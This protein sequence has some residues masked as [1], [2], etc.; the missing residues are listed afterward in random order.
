[1]QTFLPYADFK[2]CADVLDNKRLNKQHVECFQII[3]TL[4]TN[5]KS[6]RQHPITRMWENNIDALKE[7]ANCIKIECLNRNFKSEK[8]PFYTLPNEII[9]PKWL[10]W[11]LVHISHQSNLMRK[12]ASYYSQFGWKE[13]DITG[14]YWAVTPKTKQ[15]QK[16]NE[17][18]VNLFTNK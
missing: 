8:I 13:Y 17:Q 9:Y 10:G 15:A 14:Y 3:K 7:Y 18:W 12:N 6:W 5:S 16:V 4:E 2:K 1:M 11:K